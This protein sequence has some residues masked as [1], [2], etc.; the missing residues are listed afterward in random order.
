MALSF[1]ALLVMAIQ[2]ASDLFSNILC[3]PSLDPWLS[4]HHGSLP[5]LVPAIEDLQCFHRQLSSQ[6]L[7]AGPDIAASRA[8]HALATHQFYRRLSWPT[9][10]DLIQSCIETI[11]HFHSLGHTSIAHIL[12]IR[13]L[14][15]GVKL[16]EAEMEA[17]HYYWECF[18][19]N[20]AQYI[21]DTQIE[22]PPRIRSCQAFTPREL[23][24]VPRIASKVISDTR[25]DILGRTSFHIL[26][27]AGIGVQWPQLQVN[28]AD[29][30]G[31]TSLHQALCQR[32][33]AAAYQLVNQGADLALSCLSEIS[34]LH[35]AGCRGQVNTIKWLAQ[36]LPG[37]VDQPDA[38]GRSPFWYAAKSSHIGV[39]KVL[40]TTYGVD[41]ARKDSYGHS[42]F[43]AAANDGRVDVLGFLLKVNSDRQKVST[44]TSVATGDIDHTPLLLAS[45]RRHQDCVEL[46]L[47]HKS[48]KAGDNEFQNLKALAKQHGDSYLLRRL[49]LLWA[50]DTD[51][52]FQPAQNPWPNNRE[53]QEPVPSTI[54]M[55]DFNTNAW[56]EWHLG[57]AQAFSKIG[58]GFKAA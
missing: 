52:G 12:Q 23:L 29:L 21:C 51:E 22:V 53:P 42:A 43:A 13:L 47:R 3:Y 55:A 16:A 14:R 46:I 45:K 31:R 25:L 34:V 36:S 11:Q 37:M 6:I 32:D 18:T 7:A 17:V 15:A 41:I 44:S 26:A 57:H 58:G 54:Y 20:A 4:D 33:E 40:A 19:D 5:E 9:D 1:Q 8:Q 24:Y 2:E 49:D 30:F 39:M 38:I 35:I 28:Q 50:A 10:H 27:D 48:W 56:D